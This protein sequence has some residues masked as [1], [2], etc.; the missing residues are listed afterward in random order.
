MGRGKVSRRDANWWA[1]LNTAYREYIDANGSK[2]PRIW[3]EK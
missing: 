2:P 3:L 1:P